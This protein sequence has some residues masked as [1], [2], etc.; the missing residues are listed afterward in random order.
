[1]KMCKKCGKEFNNVYEFCPQCGISSIT[2]KKV[3]TPTRI[4]GENTKYI[5]ITLVIIIFLVLLII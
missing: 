3:K 1:M 2:N 5:F 4:K